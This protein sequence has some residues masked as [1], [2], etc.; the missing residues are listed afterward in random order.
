MKMPEVDYT[1]YVAILHPGGRHIYVSISQAAW[2]LPTVADDE[3]ASVATTVRSLCASDGIL[4][5]REYD[6]ATDEEPSPQPMRLLTARC[7]TTPSQLPSGVEWMDVE[8]L[9][10]APL[11]PAALRRPLVMWLE[12]IAVDEPQ[13]RYEPWAIPS[14]F[15]EACTWITEQAGRTGRSLTGPIQ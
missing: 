12:T 1:R 14:W 13:S 4:L 8:A 11:A 3:A 10:H 7:L 2:T 6:N 9:R 5:G 15:D